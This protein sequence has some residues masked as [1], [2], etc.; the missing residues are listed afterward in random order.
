MIGASFSGEADS[1]EESAPVVKFE[2]DEDFQTKIAALSVRDSEFLRRVSHLLLPDYFE[3]FSEAALVNLALKHFA[4]YGCAPDRAS[5]T[6]VLKEAIGSGQIRKDEIASIKA[7][8]LKIFS[9]P[10]Y[11]REYAEAR[12]AEFVRH[13]AVSQAILRSVALLEKKDFSKIE[14]LVKN[15]TNIGIN[16]DG[17][18]YDY[19]KAIDDR[20]ELRLDRAAGKRPPTGITTGN[21]ELDNL[22]YH[23]GWGKRELTT[24]MGGAKSGKCVVR[25]TTIFTEDGM[26]EI[27]DYVGAEVGVGSFADREVEIL[28]MKGAEKTS[29]VYN[30]GINPTIQIETH[31]GFNIEGTH[32]HPMLVIENGRHVWKRLDELRLG[33]QMVVQRGGMIFGRHTDIRFAVAA[34]LQRVAMSQRSDAISSV[35]LPQMMTPKLAEFIAMIIAEGYF[36]SGGALSFTQKDKSILDRFVALS[37]ALFGLTPR[38]YRQQ[39]RVPFARIQSVIVRAYLEALGVNWSLSSQKTIPNSI[40][41]SPKNCVVAFLSA[42]IGLECHIAKHGE[43][44]VTF[45]LIMAS[46]KMIRQVQLMLLNFGVVSRRTLKRSMATNGSR[47]MRDYWRLIVSGS[48]NIEAL[49]NL[50]VY[51]NRKNEALEVLRDDWTARDWIPGARRLIGDIMLEIQHSGFSLKSSFNASDYRQLRAL[52]SGRPNAR[53]ELTFAFAEK[54]VMKLNK[55]NVVGVNSNSLRAII[56]DNFCYDIVTNIQYSEAETVDLTVPGT[57][58]FFA[59]GLIS[60]NTTSLIGFA[61]SASIA[62]KNVLYVTLEVS[63]RILSERLDAN[64]SETLIAELGAKIYEVD[65]KV[66]SLK[67]GELLVHEFASGT[68]S[69]NMLRS[70][71]ERYRSHGKLFD[72]IVVDYA[73]IMAPNFRTQ[74]AIENSKTIYVDLRAIAFDFDA[75]V[76]TATQTNRTGHVAT[77]AK[78]EHVSEDFNKVRTVDLMISINRTE[79]EARNG[80]ARLYFAASRNQKSGFKVCIKQDLARMI[81]LLKVLR[82]E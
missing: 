15:A 30:S 27:G 2:F 31:R 7:A 51:E 22:L 38:I 42:L 64:V 60:H 9:A 41:R 48:R 16:Q 29:H 63:A 47:I 81:F 43:N 78:A 10:L 14:K 76:L 40:L 70:I 32:H 57:S 20:T 11:D 6:T 44:A 19:W 3:N 75:A 12:L 25:G 66:K 23:K 36:G 33:D 67:H 72:L 39:G 8:S 5:F 73:D 62:G 45:D 71:L 1:K 56:N 26:V 49:A 59:N 77:V 80:E 50:G 13:Q 4:S 37:E 35:T 46:E 34:A 74:D 54:L 17:E 79:E 55:L 28:G 65:G 69:P 52:R 24:I 82:I 21:I 58:S 61:K 18:V 68:L 53:R